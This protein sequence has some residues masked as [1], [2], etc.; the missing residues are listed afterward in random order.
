MALNKELQ[1]HNHDLHHRPRSRDCFPIVIAF[2]ITCPEIIRPLHFSPT[3]NI[4][5]QMRTG[6]LQIEPHL[7][8]SFSTIHTDNRV[9]FW[10]H[11][12][13]HQVKW[14]RFPQ[15]S[16]PLTPI[17]HY[18]NGTSR[19]TKTSVRPP[20]QRHEKR[21]VLNGR[22]ELCRV[23]FALRNVRW[24]PVRYGGMV[25]IFS[26]IVNSAQK[27]NTAAHYH[28]VAKRRK[29]SVC[30]RRPSAYFFAGKACR[31]Q[32]PW[33][34]Q[35]SYTSNVPSDGKARFTGD[36]R[37]SWRRDDVQADSW[38]IYAIFPTFSSA[39]GLL[40]KVMKFKNVCPFRWKGYK[41][42]SLFHPPTCWSI[43]KFLCYILA[44]LKFSIC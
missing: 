29:L 34:E 39:R 21:T 27:K 40:G 10:C 18:S 11:V 9:E 4:T 31:Q 5:D 16:L 15:V 26:L 36:Y 23:H 6:W 41:L 28:T 12:L 2:K 22:L 8:L 38:K 13:S 44:S 7:F 42:L 17:F 3:Q 19:Q 25:S 37:G 43:F 30:E 14:H 35:R 1:F 20:Q 24:Q 32:C 33:V